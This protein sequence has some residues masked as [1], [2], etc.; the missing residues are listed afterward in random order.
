MLRFEAIVDDD[1]DDPGD[2]SDGDALDMIALILL[3]VIVYSLQLQPSYA[4][5]MS[6]GSG[7]KTS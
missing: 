2:R 4:M 3:L 1:G 5:T 6:A 7:G